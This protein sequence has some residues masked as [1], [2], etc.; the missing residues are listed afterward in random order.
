MSDFAKE[1]SFDEKT[2]GN[3]STRDKSL[4]TLLQS[5]A[6]KVSGISTKFSPENP[7]ELCDKLNFLLQEKQAGNNSDIIIEENIAIVD[8]PL[9]YK[10]ISTTKHRFL[11]LKC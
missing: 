5:P 3:K 1:L 11:L 4:I 2:L 9:E 10:R 8:K 7:N 6:I